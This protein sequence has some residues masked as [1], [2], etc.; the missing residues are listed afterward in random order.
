[1]AS[2]TL[3]GSLTVDLVNISDHS[4]RIWKDSNSWGASR[5]RLLRLR[6]ASIETFVQKKKSTFTRNV[7]GFEE[8]PKGEHLTKPLTLNSEEWDVPPTG[9]SFQPGDVVI[10]V[11]DVPESPEARSMTVWHGFATVAATAK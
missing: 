10:V 1:M 4:I 9:I 6:G 8:I 11:Y 7:P 5:W 2:L 3:S